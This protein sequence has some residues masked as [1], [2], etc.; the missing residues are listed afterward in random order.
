MFVEVDAAGKIIRSEMLTRDL[1]IHD[2]Q[3]DYK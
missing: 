1:D 3:D 2:W